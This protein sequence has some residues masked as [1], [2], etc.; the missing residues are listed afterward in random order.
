MEKAKDGRDDERTRGQG[1]EDRNEKGR[2]G[3]F[4]NDGGVGDS[5]DDSSLLHFSSLSLSLS[6]TLTR[7][8]LFLFFLSISSSYSI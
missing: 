5:V 8:T 3:T 6:P 2:K 7:S 4:D 1:R